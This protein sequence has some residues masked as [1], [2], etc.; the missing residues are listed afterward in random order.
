[1]RLAQIFL[2]GQGVV[3]G[4]G[5]EVED[6]GV[7]RAETPAV[8]MVNVACQTDSP[9]FIKLMMTLYKYDCQ[10]EQSHIRGRNLVAVKSTMVLVDADCLPQPRA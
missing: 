1:M 10:F 2:G 4:W 3:L 9:G 5:L 7:L 6:A 8:S